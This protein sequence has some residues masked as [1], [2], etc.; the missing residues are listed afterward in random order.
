M[1]KLCFRSLLS[2]AVLAASAFGV[3]LARGDEP[4]APDGASPEAAGVAENAGSTE[5]GSS[6]DAG[7]ASDASSWFR[8]D[9]DG[10]GTQLWAGAAHSVGGLEIAS[11]IYVV[12][13][14]A[15]LDVGPSFQLGSLNVTAMAGLGFDFAGEGLVSLIA[16][17]IYLILDHHGW[18]GE[19]WNE[20]FLNSVFDDAAEDEL[21]TRN[22][23]LYEVFDG[24][25]LGPQVE[26]SV[27]VRGG[28][29]DPPREL[30]S[31]PVGGRV[32][33]A[34]GSKNTLGIFLAYETKAADEDSGLAGRFTFVRE[35]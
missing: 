4:T 6:P 12:D 14:F 2:A 35:F 33:L 22:F 23:L 17:Q 28:V 31:L 20:L 15:E 13:T 27:R 32:N 11:D 16:P 10:Y 30:I 5:G 26:A 19:S 9:T 34:Y 8:I 18:Y 3:R 24:F 7:G 21:Y 29:D 1:E 25:Y